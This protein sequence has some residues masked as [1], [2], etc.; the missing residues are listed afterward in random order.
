MQPT[1]LT[2]YGLYL[3]TQ[4][5]TGRPYTMLP[6]STLNERL[7][8]LSGVA[9]QSMLYPRMNYLVI[10]NKGHRNI[11]G[12]NNISVEVPRQHE[13]LHASLF[14]L[15]PFVIRDV[16]NDLPVHERARYC[17]RTEENY[18]GKRY[19]AY[20]GRRLDYTNAS[21]E[22][23]II[24][25]EDGIATVEPI[26]QHLTRAN[27]FPVPQDLS[28]TGLNVLQGKYLRTLMHLRIDF[29]K[30]ET[31]ELI[32]VANIIHGDPRTAIISE[33][34]L[35]AGVDKTVRLTDGTHYDEVIA[36]TITHHCPVYNSALYHDGGFH[37]DIAVGNST[38]LFRLEEDPINTAKAYNG[39][40]AK[41]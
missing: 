22:L 16:N 40:P 4:S 29:T 12:A 35:V 33:L 31:E 28:P 26:E 20:Y 21:N 24:T 37:F 14:N 41:P 8:I 18:D 5:F 1:T 17:L 3:Q 7:D 9:P 13:A 38:P 11:N 39:T 6:N 27:L 19:I 25:V 32:N 30:E 10:G 34:G 36:A 23:S 15:T 2:L